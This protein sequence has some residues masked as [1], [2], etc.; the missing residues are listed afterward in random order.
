MRWPMREHRDVHDPD[1]VPMARAH[2]D[3]DHRHR[4]PMPYG[5]EE[6]PRRA[7]SQ[8]SYLTWLALGIASP[9][10]LGAACFAVLAPAAYLGLSFVLGADVY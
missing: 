10:L 7:E 3:G 2:E 9:F 6:G 4:G 1:T 8:D 5:P